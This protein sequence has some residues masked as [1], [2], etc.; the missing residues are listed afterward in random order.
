MA[1]EPA[2]G[3]ETGSPQRGK[4][5]VRAKPAPVQVNWRMAYIRTVCLV[6]K[7]GEA[8]KTYRYAGTAAED[9]QELSSG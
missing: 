8:I 1:E 7:Y 2:P 9:P 4:P 6:D 5:Y 3:A